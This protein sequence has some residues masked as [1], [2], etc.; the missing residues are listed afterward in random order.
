[1]GEEGVGR[2]SRDVSQRQGKANGLKKAEWTG[3]DDAL[4]D[5]IRY[6]TREA[7][8]RNLEREVANLTRKA[9]KEILMRRLKKITVS[10]RNLEKFAGVRRFRY[11]EVEETDLVGVT[12][13][14]AWTEGRGELLSI[15]A[16]TVPGRGGGIA[17]RHRGD[18]VEEAAHGAGGF[19]QPPCESLRLH[20]PTL[21]ENGL[22]VT[23]PTG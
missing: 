15:Q 9:I 11:G 14:L 10:R 19:V 13:G 7:G 6:Y 4:R 16:V 18:G 17:A 5:L 22:H 12:T 23:C 1:M 8:V 3:T 21:P 20:P 2:A